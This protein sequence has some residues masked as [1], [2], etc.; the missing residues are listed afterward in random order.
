M[1]GAIASATTGQLNLHRRNQ[2]A[3]TR[4]IHGNNLP[5]SIPIHIKDALTRCSIPG[6]VLYDYD[7]ER[8]A[9]H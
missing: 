8:D 6:A 2:A 1:H 7:L 4:N 5:D 9:H 3:T